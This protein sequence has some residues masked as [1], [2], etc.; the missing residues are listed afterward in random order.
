MCEQTPPAFH[1]YFTLFTEDWRSVARKFLSSRERIEEGR[2]N[3]CKRNFTSIR[4]RP[5]WDL[6][7]LAFPDVIVLLPQ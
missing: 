1:F 3:S 2:R 4:F 7:I 6:L 5:K